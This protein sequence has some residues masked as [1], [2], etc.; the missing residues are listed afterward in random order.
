VPPGLGNRVA[1][2]GGDTRVGAMLNYRPGMRLT[3]ALAAGGGFNI[4]SD[5]E[6][7]RI[8]RGSLKKPIV[9][10]YDFDE[11]IAGKTGDV[12]LAPGDVVFVTRHWS[13]AF[14]E[15]IDRAAPLLGLGLGVASFVVLYKNYD[16]TKELTNQ[17]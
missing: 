7:I 4:S 12:E 6:D 17:Q 10:L 3:E 14:G 15:L 2:L 13:A 16:L 5:S 11:L 9:Y 1:V 8:I